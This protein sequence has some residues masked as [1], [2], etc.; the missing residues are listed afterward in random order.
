M[1]DLDA[2]I[3]PFVLAMVPLGFVGVISLL[4]FYFKINRTLF[5]E[6]YALWEYLG[7]PGAGMW[8]VPR[9]RGIWED[10]RATN[11]FWKDKWFR[12]NEEHR[13]LFPEDVLRLFHHLH[14]ISRLIAAFT[15]IIWLMLI[16]AVLSDLG[17]LAFEIR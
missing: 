15:V 9:R 11:Q 6:H 5:L 17:Q 13:I 14:R 16:T 10:N 12:L 4:W 7:C 2:F 3:D 8:S 1:N